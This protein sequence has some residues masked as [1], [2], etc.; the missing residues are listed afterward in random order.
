MAPSRSVIT[1]YPAAAKALEAG[2]PSAAGSGVVGSVMPDSIQN[3][4]AIDKGAALQF[5][6]IGLSDDL[7]RCGTGP[8][9]GVRPPHVALLPVQLDR[10]SS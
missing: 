8:R 5:V 1:R 2:R 10:T 4:R 7:L 6:A 9:V 3:E